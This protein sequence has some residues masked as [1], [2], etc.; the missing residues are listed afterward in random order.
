M[1]AASLPQDHPIPG[2][3]ALLNL[4]A[5]SAAPRAEFLG[6][7]VMVLR[8]DTGWLAVV[9]IPLTSAPGVQTLKYSNAR[10]QRARLNFTVQA[11]HYREQHLT[12]DNQRMVEPTPDDLKRINA[13]TRRIQAALAHWRD[14]AAVNP[15][16][17]QPVAGER[18]DSFGARRFFNGQSRKPHSGMDIAAASGTP[19]TAPADGVVIETGN[20]FFNGNTVFI[21]HGQGL[22][23]M[24][25]HL[26]RIDVTPGTVLTRGAR[27]GAV[28]MTGR[29]TG[30]HLH[31]GV[32]L[33]QA[34]ID[35]ALL[36]D[37]TAAP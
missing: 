25:C 9:G 2:G 1:Q 24:Y 13:D 33:N 6:H 22:I 5:Q 21:D 11:A 29:V 17:A 18:S 37:T 10:N 12:L 7:R 28:G 8:K 26:Q 15:L 3:I 23:T 31:W 34:F 16:L 4:P 36:I 27:I 14:S 19:V 35:P 32:S 20:Y 30:P